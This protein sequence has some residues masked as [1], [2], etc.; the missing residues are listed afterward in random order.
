MGAVTWLA[1]RDVYV[2]GSTVTPFK[3]WPEKSHFDLVREAYLAV[4]EDSG[5][6]PARIEATAFGCCALHLFGQSNLRGQVLLLPL[7]REGKYP[8]NAP[9]VNVEAGCATGAL[10]LAQAR[11]QVASGEC[12]IALAL[13]V[14]KVFIPEAPHKM[15]ELFEAGMDLLRPEEWQ[16]LY[17][18]SA[19]ECGTTYAPH[20]ARI[21]ILDAVALSA[22]WHMKRYGTTKEHLAHV[23]SKN[24]AHGVM[25]PNAQYRE[26][27]SV[28]AVLADKAVVHPFTRAM[29]APMSDGASAVLVGTK[30]ALDSLGKNRPRVRI[31]A[32]SAANGARTSHNED[33]VTKVA[34]KRAFAKA[35]IAP[36]ALSLAEVHDATAFAEIAA[37]EDIGICNEG[38]G[39]PFTASGATSLGGSIPVNT[40]GGLESKGHPLAASGLAMTH[41]IRLQLEGRAGERQSKSPTWGLVHNAGGLVAFDESTSVVG[42]LEREA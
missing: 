33:S 24:H 15:K 41:E 23:A 22:S 5:L 19:A 18:A 12:D 21:T 27:I 34:A 11:A 29:C 42:L 26:A 1:M 30:E 40:S 28:E 4:L 16:A 8:K 10:A 35:G 25:N 9:I 13:G 38:E 14:E 2:L 3:R 20:P 6:D 17:A 32:L 36:S 31:A 7:L 39:G 37:I